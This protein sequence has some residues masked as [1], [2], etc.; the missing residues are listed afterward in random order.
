[1]GGPFLQPPHVS[2]SGGF[3]SASVSIEARAE[4]IAITLSLDSFCDQNT[5]NKRCFHPD[6]DS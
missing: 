2:L 3:A 5:G 4:D 1:M 6:A